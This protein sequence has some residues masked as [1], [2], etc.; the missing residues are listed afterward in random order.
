MKKRLPDGGGGRL[1]SPGDGVDLGGLWAGERGRQALIMAI[2]P[3]SA[4]GVVHPS[5]HRAHPKL[6][7]SRKILGSGDPALDGVGE[8]NGAGLCD[9]SFAI[10]AWELLAR[11]SFRTQG[12]RREFFS[13]LGGWYTLPPTALGVGGTRS[14]WNAKGSTAR[15]TGS[16]EKA[17][18]DQPR[19]GG[20][21]RYGGTTMGSGTVRMLRRTRSIKA[22]RPKPPRPGGVMLRFG[23]MRA[24]SNAAF[25]PAYRR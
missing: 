2:D 19:S 22:E 14:Q 13:F 11:L 20:T 18:T 17:G 7:R 3:G 23:E 24:I 1:Q 10:S 4:R 8:G 5:G 9:G 21:R 15:G 6:W 16:G 12:A 25:G